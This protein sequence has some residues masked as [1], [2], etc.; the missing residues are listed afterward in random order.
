M[1]EELNDGSINQE[2]V[3]NEG[4]VNNEP[5]IND[6]GN[7]PTETN[8]DIESLNTFLEIPEDKR[9]KS[10]DDFKSRYVDMNGRY[11]QYKDLERVKKELGD[12]RLEYD[13]HL[14]EVEELYNE[15]NPEKIFG[16]KEAYRNYLVKQEVLKDTSRNPEVVDVILSNDVNSFDEFELVFHSKMLNTPGLNSEEAIADIIYNELGKSEDDLKDEDGNEITIDTKADL[17][18]LLKPHEIGKLKNMARDAK[19]EL[20]SIKN[21]EVNVDNN[22]FN[23]FQAKR[24]GEK[25]AKEEHINSLK[26]SWKT[27]YDSFRDIKSVQLTEKDKE[28]NEQVIFDFPIDSGVLSKIDQSVEEYVLNHNIEPTDENIQVVRN[29]FINGYASRNWEKIVRSALT[30]AVQGERQKNISERENRQPMNTQQNTTNPIKDVGKI[31]EERL[32]KAGWY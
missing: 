17:F 3:V 13:N 23:S 1:A 12:K 29:E 11:D 27:H 20:L 24:E 31:N 26:E 25:K 8:F 6:G 2:P 30:Q 22:Y 14:K 21:T 10:A 28:G 7:E 18:K 19:R 5:I 4:G 32:R 9:F 16:S 15:A